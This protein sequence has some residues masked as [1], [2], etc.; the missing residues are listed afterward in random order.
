MAQAVDGMAVEEFPPRP[1]LVGRKGSIKAEPLKSKRIITKRIPR[2]RLGA[3]EN[4][5]LQAPPESN[6]RSR[7]HRYDRQEATEVTPRRRRRYRANVQESQP[8]T[9]RIRRRNKPTDAPPAAQAP[10]RQPQ[11]APNNP[12]PQVKPT[13]SWRERLRPVER[14]RSNPP[15]ASAPNPTPGFGSDG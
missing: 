7:R 8:Q 12:V 1:K 13:R 3:G 10:Q 14:P 5:V 9:R 15:P 2:R 6:R 4:A 11:Q